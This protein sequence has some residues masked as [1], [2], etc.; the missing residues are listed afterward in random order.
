MKKLLGWFFVPF[1]ILREVGSF[2]IMI[3]LSMLIALHDVVKSRF[4]IGLNNV[5]SY[6]E[7]LLEGI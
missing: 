5:V 6:V 4:T 2:V 3:V 1:I 7:K